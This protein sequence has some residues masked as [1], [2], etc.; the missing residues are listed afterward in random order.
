MYDV[1]IRKKVLKIQ[2]RLG[3]RIGIPYGISK[4]PVGFCTM[5]KKAAQVLTTCFSYRL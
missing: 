3:M 5:R 1:L 4:I 2:E